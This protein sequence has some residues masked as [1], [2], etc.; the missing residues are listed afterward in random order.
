MIDKIKNKIVIPLQELG[1]ELV[2]IEVTKKFGQENLTIYIDKPEGIQL[3]DCEK[4]HHL[5]DPIIEEI[6]PFDETYILNVSSPGLD[7]H[8]KTQ[9]DFERNYNKNIEIKLISPLKGKK[10]IEGILINRDDKFIVL[11]TKQGETKL[12]N[13][14]INFARPLVKFE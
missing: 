14:K 1:Y 13:T 11:K 10:Y 8:F 6:D 2:D 9:R 3:D 4:A 7:R 5:I 12:E